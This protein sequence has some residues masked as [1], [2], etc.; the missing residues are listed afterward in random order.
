VLARVTDRPDGE[1]EMAVGHDD[2]TDRP[3]PIGEGRQDTKRTSPVQRDKMHHE[4]KLEVSFLVSR[5][6]KTAYEVDS[7]K[8]ELVKSRHQEIGTNKS[9]CIY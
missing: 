3:D 7:C 9:A 2:L 8:P 6:T 1:I 4:S 5:K